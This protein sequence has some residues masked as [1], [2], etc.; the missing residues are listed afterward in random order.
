MSGSNSAEI[1]L[2]TFS[3]GTIVE[4]LATPTDFD[5]LTV[6]AGGLLL[7]WVKETHPNVEHR[8]D[9]EEP[10][11]TMYSTRSK[12]TIASRL[13]HFI[14]VGSQLQ[15]VFLAPTQP[16]STY[17]FVRGYNANMLSIVDNGDNVLSVETKIFLT[18]VSEVIQARKEI[19]FNVR[20]LPVE[21]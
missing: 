13:G 16:T 4:P 11:E 6:L 7:D 10:Q 20:A 18:K 5:R 12:V 21:E 2:T 1:S 15:A 8:Y 9:F 3:P 14:G 19:D 17:R